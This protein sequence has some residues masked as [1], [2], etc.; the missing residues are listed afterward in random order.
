MRLHKYHESKSIC[1]NYLATTITGIINTDRHKDPSILRESSFLGI[2]K[3][4]RQI[5]ASNSLQLLGFPQKTVYMLEG[6]S[7]LT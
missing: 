5:L 1:F 4:N 6:I 2:M 3:T 7:A